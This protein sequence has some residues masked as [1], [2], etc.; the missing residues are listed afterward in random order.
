MGAMG[1]DERSERYL[2][3]AACA[4]A[5]VAWLCWLAF[6][7]G[8]WQDRLFLVSLTAVAGTLA[9]MGNLCRREGDLR[10]WLPASVAGLGLLVQVGLTLPEGPLHVWLMAA[11]G[12]AGAAAAWALRLLGRLMP[13][14]RK[15]SPPAA[16]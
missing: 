7:L 16:L 4:I 6:G 1:A 13:A 14:T 3:I 8:G 5:S 15:S 12:L 10:A 2:A 9:W 11:A